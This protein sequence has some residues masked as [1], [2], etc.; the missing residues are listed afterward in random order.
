M[1]THHT[2][3]TK[4]REKTRKEKKNRDNDIPKRRLVFFCILFPLLIASLVRLSP[5]QECLVDHEWSSR[6]PRRPPL[7]ALARSIR[8]ALLVSDS[9]P[10]ALSVCLALPL[11]LLV[12][13]LVLFLFFFSDT[14]SYISLQNKH[15]LVNSCEFSFSFF[16]FWL[17][18][19]FYVLTLRY[20]SFI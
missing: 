18:V 1:R 4:T 16:Q 7:A 9:A 15:L 12:F 19:S 3:A 14:V 11:P 20:F 6:R 2:P 10:L 5:T 17:Y 13:V 8:L